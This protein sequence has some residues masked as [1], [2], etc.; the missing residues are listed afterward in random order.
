M[1]LIAQTRKSRYV[2]IV[3]GLVVVYAVFNKSINDEVGLLYLRVAN[4]ESIKINNLSIEVPYKYV[5]KVQQSDVTFTDFPDGQGTIIVRSEF[6]YDF[7]KYV[8]NY[9]RHIKLIN[10]ELIETGKVTISGAQGFLIRSGSISHKDIEEVT[11]LIP[12]KRVMVNYK[13]NHHK[14]DDYFTIIQSIKFTN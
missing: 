8:D 1:P 10:Y 7:D 4:T 5:R 3:L 12:E 11:V 14:W 9:L 13:G 2:L 6:V